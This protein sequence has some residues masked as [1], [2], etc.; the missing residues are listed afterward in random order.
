[1]A[2]YIDHDAPPTGWGEGSYVEDTARDR[3]FP[4]TIGA[5]IDKIGGNATIGAA[6]DKIGGNATIGAPDG[7]AI[8]EIGGNREPPA[9]LLPELLDG[10]RPFSRRTLRMGRQAVADRIT[11]PQNGTENTEG[12]A[13]RR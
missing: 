10:A 7:M 9:T 12:R 13:A 11:E 5:A 3:G 4:A 6:I 8:D 2:S 1:M